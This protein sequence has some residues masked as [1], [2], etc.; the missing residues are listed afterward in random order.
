MSLVFHVLTIFPD[1]FVSPLSVSLLRRAIEKGIIE[2]DLV[3]IR[4]YSSLKH[5][6]VDDEIYGEGAGMLMIADVVGAAIEKNYTPGDGR[7]AIYLTP[8]GEV[9]TQS[10][11]EK[12]AGYEEILLLCGRYEGVD[13]RV[14]D[15]HIDMEISVGD[16]VL[17]GG[18]SAALILMECVTRLL[19]GSVGKEESVREDSF[20][21]G[22]LE[23]PHYTRPARW[24]ELSVP[25]VLRSGNHGEVRKW[26]LREALRTTFERRPDLLLKKKLNEEEKRILKEIWSEDWNR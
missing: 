14:I 1:Y 16:Y 17:P 25:E 23:G 11:C 22:L 12:L 3:D 15:T 5:R 18:E 2:V 24:R 10:I 26:R 7:T 8:R 19:P 20:S 6:N 21:T 13:Q 4:N 9:L